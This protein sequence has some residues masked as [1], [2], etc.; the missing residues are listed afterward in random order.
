MISV[1][2]GKND[3]RVII[4]ILTPQLIQHSP[5]VLVDHADLSVVLCCES[6]H[7][8]LRQLCFN[9]AAQRQARS[10]KHRMPLHAVLVITSRKCDL[11]RVCPA[12]VGRRRQI[13]LVRAEIREE[14]KEGTVIRAVR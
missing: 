8:I 14:E 12:V 7:L 5:D 9:A 4:Q 2:R 10:F 1:V 11:I 13:R 6:A 3:H